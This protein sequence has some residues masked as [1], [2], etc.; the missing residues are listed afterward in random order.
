MW[1]SRRESPFACFSACFLECFSACFSP[2]APA[3]ANI[4]TQ[5]GEGALRI[6]FASYDRDGTGSLDALE[7]AAACKDLGFEMA[8]HQIFRE[9]DSDGSGEVSYAELVHRVLESVPSDQTTR[10]LLTT[11]VC[12]L[13]S[14]RKERIA[15][16]DT[17]G[18]RITGTDPASVREQ[19]RTMLKKSGSHVGELIALFDDDGG[20]LNVQVDDV[21]FAKVRA[22]LS[23]GPLLA[24]CGLERIPPNTPR[25]W[26]LLAGD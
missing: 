23:A 12:S 1:F 16:V 22:Q 18:W 17:S 21:E 24:L 26:H 5:F 15:S 13:E 6:A 25:E 19:I 14:D 4:S 8:A 3:V 7:F 9:L 20:R 2:R 11:L 10:D